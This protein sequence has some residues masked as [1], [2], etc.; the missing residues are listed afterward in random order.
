MG[1]T[2]KG[3]FDEKPTRAFAGEAYHDAVKHRQAEEKKLAAKRRTRHFAPTSY[4]TTAVA[5]WPLLC[6]LCPV[7]SVPSAPFSR[8]D[9]SARLPLPDH[10]VSMQSV[11]GCVRYRLRRW[12]CC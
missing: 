5:M 7:G 9:T 10:T 8:P 1:G 4:A 12:C 11:P 3:L 2:I 6:L